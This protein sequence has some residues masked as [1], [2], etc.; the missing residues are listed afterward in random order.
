MLLQELKEQAY[1]L[2]KG[3]TIQNL[4]FDNMTTEKINNV[5]NSEKDRAPGK[6]YQGEWKS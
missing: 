5:M 4:D 2:S 1:K 3:D 6:H